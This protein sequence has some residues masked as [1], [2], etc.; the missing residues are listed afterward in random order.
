M[1][2]RP[3]RGEVWRVQ[4]DPS[5][6][7]E[8]GGTRPAVIISADGFNQG[9]SGMAI[10]AP[11]TSVYKRIPYHVEISPSEGGLTMTSYVKCEDVRALSLDRFSQQLGKL[12]STTMETINDRLR[13]VLDL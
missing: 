4:L 8:Q 10:V 6:G 9:R 5:V 13:V 3:T 11:L 7:H 2:F 1:P 12:S